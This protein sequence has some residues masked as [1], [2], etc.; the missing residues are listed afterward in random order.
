MTETPLDWMAAANKKAKGKRPEMVAFADE[1]HVPAFL[2]REP[3]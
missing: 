3:R 2:L 1:D